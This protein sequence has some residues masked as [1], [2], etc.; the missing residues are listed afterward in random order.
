[1][2]LVLA[3][4]LLQCLGIHQVVAADDTPGNGPASILTSEIGRLNNESLFWG[5]YKPNLYF[6]VR[7][8][9]ANPLWTG[10]MWAKVDSFQDV[11]TGTR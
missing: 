11:Q 5:P 7:P 1:M 6:G 10:L 3:F 4:S 2:A 8:R 9:T